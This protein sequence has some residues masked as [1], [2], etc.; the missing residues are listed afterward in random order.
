MST[1][2]VVI[3]VIEV[4]RP[5]RGWRGELTSVKTEHVINGFKTEEDAEEVASELESHAD[6][7]RR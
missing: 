1:Y 2:R 3:Q 7:T 6:E 5:K 4:M